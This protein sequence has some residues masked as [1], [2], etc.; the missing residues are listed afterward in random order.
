M[1]KVLITF[2]RE[3]A[4]AIS[5]MMYLISRTRKPLTSRM[6]IFPACTTSIYQRTVVEVGGHLK[7]PVYTTIISGTVRLNFGTRANNSW[8]GN[9]SFAM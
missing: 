5:Y 6:D 3:N 9:P 8:P 2:T 1:L 7:S 4:D